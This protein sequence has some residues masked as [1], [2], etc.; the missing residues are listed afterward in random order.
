[1]S[2]LRLA[3]AFALS[4]LV[5]ILAYAASASIDAGYPQPSSSAGATGSGF[6]NGFVGG[7]HTGCS[8]TGSITGIGF[9]T[10]N[11]WDRLD[12]HGTITGSEDPRWDVE[13]T[14][15]VR[16]TVTVQNNTPPGILLYSLSAFAR[17]EIEYAGTP[18]VYHEVSPLV[19]ITKEATFKTGYGEFTTNP[20]NPV[21]PDKAKNPNYKKNGSQL[22]FWYKVTTNG[23]I[24]SGRP[25]PTFGSTAYVE[26]SLNGL[27]RAYDGNTLITT[28]PIQ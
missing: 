23:S 19:S 28:F 8:T 6:T 16:A 10:G 4:L 13:L 3:V 26:T 24:T 5:P 9:G 1:M 2:S 27:V 17:L 11:A 22:Q 21:A 18:A 20:G 7:G 15:R 12:W 14:G 25:G